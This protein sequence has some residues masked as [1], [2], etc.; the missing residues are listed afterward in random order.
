MKFNSNAILFSIIFSIFFLVAITPRSHRR[1]NKKS[2]FNNCH[3]ISLSDT[4]LYATCQDSNGS[5]KNNKIDLDDCLAYT[6][7][8]LVKGN[9]FSRKCMNCSLRQNI[10]RCGCGQLNQVT[11]IKVNLDFVIDNVNGYLQC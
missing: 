3:S 9:N 5:Y 2:F 11:L 6:S 7:G 8:S 10:L 1:R 4:K